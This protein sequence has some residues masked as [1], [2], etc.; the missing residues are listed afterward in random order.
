MT[1]QEQELDQAAIEAFTG[2]LV[3]TFVNATTTAM[4]SLGHRVGLFEAAALGPAT[5][6]ELAER[7]SVD[8][9][10]VREWLGAVTSAGIFRY[11][12]STSMYE[13]PAEHAVL[14]TGETSANLAGEAVLVS[15]LNRFVEPVAD[16]FRAG[17]G[18]PYDA[19]RPEFTSI[20]DSL[21]R[22]IYDE[23]LVDVYIPMADGLRERLVAG[24]RAADFGT[25]AGHP[26]NLLAQAFPASTFVGYDIAADAIA[27][28]SAE[29]AAYGIANVTFEQRDVAAVDDVAVFDAV[30][31]FDAIHDQADP[32]GVLRNIRRSLKDDGVFVMVDI[33]ASSH[34]EENCANPIAPLLYGVSVLHCMTVSLA[35]GGA[36]L[37]TA[38]G[39]QLACSMLR[40]ARFS[41]IEVN[42]IPQDPFNLVYVCRP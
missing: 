3:T 22:R 41:S 33:K 24:A 19:Y 12:S 40:D 32:G 11:D 18:V 39:E 1:V 38:W 2:Q 23:A 5:S 6:A 14:L 15:Y 36:G 20:M 31:A 7:A 10:Y 28:A 13:L 35:Y 42:E 26:L 9:R 34:L 37:G 8:E 21:N 27:A 29:A 25:G 4:I 30:F 17:G 16:A